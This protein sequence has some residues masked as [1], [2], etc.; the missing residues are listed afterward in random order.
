MGVFN[1]ERQGWTWIQVDAVPLSN[2]SDES[3]CGVF[4]S[5]SDITEAR[6]LQRAMIQAQKLEAIGQLAGGIAHDFNNI[7]GS[8]LGFTELAHLRIA[9]SDPKVAGYLAQVETAGARARDLVGKLLIYSRGESGSASEPLAVTVLIIECIA[10]MRPLVPVRVNIVFDEPADDLMLLID[11]LH[12][13]Q[14]IINLGINSG[15]AMRTGGQLKIT[16]DVVNVD[17]VLCRITQKRFS[18]RWLRIG[19]ADSGSGIDES[20]IENI[21]QPFVTTKEVGKGSGMG[22]AVVAGLVGGYGGH[23]LVSSEPGDGTEFSLLFP[24]IDPV[25]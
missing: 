5:F 18:G 12:F 22:L 3:A 11:P 4:T 21:F 25:G 15:D 10:L 13:Q 14:I 17:N 6:Q 9:K 24:T 16:A 8:M 2:L 19:V 1:P 23:V 7:L 20:L